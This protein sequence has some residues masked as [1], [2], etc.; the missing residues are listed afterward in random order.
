M[1]LAEPGWIIQYDHDPQAGRA[2]RIAVLTRLAKS[3]ELVF[4]PHCPFPG[5]GRVAAKGDGFVWRP[6]P[7]ARN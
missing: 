1:S 3:H 7:M 4:A 6:M 5:V 2:N